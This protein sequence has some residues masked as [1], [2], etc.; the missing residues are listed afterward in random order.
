MME[1]ITFATTAASVS[2]AVEAGRSA[3]ITLDDLLVTS[4]FDD[5]TLRNNLKQFGE[6]AEALQSRLAIPMAAQGHDVE[7]LH[8]LHS[9]LRSAMSMC[10]STFHQLTQHA[11]GAGK[12]KSGLFRQTRKLSAKDDIIIRSKQRVP[13]HSMTVQ[14]VLATLNVYV[15]PS[16]CQKHH[17]LMKALDG[18]LSM[19]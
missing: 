13:V 11:S 3:S 18:A 1:V 19:S 4:K 17:E 2:Q 5:P 12:A 7:K 6:D 8:E 15:I 9:K 16:S 10:V 14:L